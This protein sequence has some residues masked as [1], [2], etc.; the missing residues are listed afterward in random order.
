MAG[1]RAPRRDAVANRE[2]VVEAA[3][4]VIGECGLGAPLSAIAAEAGVGAATFYRSFADR[5]ELLVELE[6]RAYAALIAVI[7][8]LESAGIGGLAAVEGFLERS[9]ELERQL[10]LPLHGAPPLVDPGSAADRR[11]I[12]GGIERF[13]AQA[14]E[15]GTVRSDANA[16][17]VILCSALVTQPRLHALD[18]RRSGRRHI[19]LFVAGIAGAGSLPGPPVVQS[20]LES[21]W[22]RAAASRSAAPPSAPE[23]IR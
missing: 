5:D 23:R 3:L 2:R 8:D 17:D 1:S 9:L 21:T 18:R 13:L 19:A 14:R 12:D 22:S 4:T 6:R 10:I 11:R 15:A 20:D 16:T 7:D